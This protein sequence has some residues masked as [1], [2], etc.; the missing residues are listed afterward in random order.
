MK[1]DLYPLG[2]ID[3]TNTFAKSRANHWD[4]TALTVL[5]AK[6]QTGGRGR[7]DRHWVSPRG[8]NIYVSYVIYT[9]PRNPHLTS[10]SLAGGVAVA[11]TLELCGVSGITL[12]WPNDVLVNGKKIAGILVETLEVDEKLC[13][14]VGVGLNVLSSKEDCEGITQ[15]VTSVVLEC[16]REWPPELVLKMLTAQIEHYLLLALQHGFEGFSQEYCG[17]LKHR[18][19]DAM[20]VRDS[21]GIFEGV[22]KEG[23]IKLRLT[24]GEVKVCF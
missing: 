5:S 12:K 13:V 24:N 1:K 19:G 2:S 6:E 8:K 20:V 21:E 22:T 4:K 18:L 11:R 16:G 9:E 23:A 15:P 17:L 14:V 10:V 7:F 3:S